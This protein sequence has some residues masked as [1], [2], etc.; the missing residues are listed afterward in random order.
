MEKT[1][2]WQRILRSLQS[3]A[4]VNRRLT[5]W[6]IDWLKQSPNISS[7]TVLNYETVK[8]NNIQH[9]NRFIYSSFVLISF[10]LILTSSVDVYV[11]SCIFT[12]FIN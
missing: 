8:E 1:S 2:H 12:I 6:L 4:P 11:L 9:Q 10:V 3:V 7:E 5:D